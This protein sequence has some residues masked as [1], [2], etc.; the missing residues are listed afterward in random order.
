MG[1]NF[2]GLLRHYRPVFAAGGLS[3]YYSDLSV[4]RGFFGGVV[5]PMTTHPSH[6]V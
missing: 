1:D 3:Q 2:E 5:P 4:L 6:R